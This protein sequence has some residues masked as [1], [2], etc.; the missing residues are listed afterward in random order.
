[1]Q[2]RRRKIKEAIFV[3]SQMQTGLIY[4]QV[5]QEADPSQGFSESDLLR[6]YYQEKLMT[7][8]RKIGKKK[9]STYGEN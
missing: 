6:K 1:M 8:G 7:K 9:K 3:R 5:L 4:S 2:I